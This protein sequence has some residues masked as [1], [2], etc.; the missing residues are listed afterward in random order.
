MKEK[1]IIDYDNSIIIEEKLITENIKKHKNHY[2]NPNAKVF[3][4]KF[5]KVSNRWPKHLYTIRDIY[6]SVKG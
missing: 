2:L 3:I 6:I 4:D 1:T 5:L